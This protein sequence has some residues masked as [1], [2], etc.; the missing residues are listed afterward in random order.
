MELQR[1]QTDPRA[2]TLT[3]LLIRCRNLELFFGF[4]GSWVLSD[5]ATVQP[6][7]KGQKGRGKE[8]YLVAVI[9]KTKDWPLEC[10]CYF[11]QSSKD[12]I[13]IATLGAEKETFLLKRL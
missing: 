12:G 13:L 8:G 7:N 2:Q 10:H 3:L 6:R 9:L 1:F 4:L 11:T 5:D